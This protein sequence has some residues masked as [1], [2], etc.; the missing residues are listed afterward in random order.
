M[1]KTLSFCAILS[2]MALAACAGPEIQTKP[3]TADLAPTEVRVAQAGD[4]WVAMNKISGK[5]ESGSVVQVSNGVAVYQG[6]DGCTYARNAANPFAPSVQWKDCGGYTGTMEIVSSEG[7]ILPLQVGAAQTWV[8]KG[9]NDS[10]DT[11]DDTRTC[12]VVG[13]ENVTVPAG[14]FDAFKVDCQASFRDRTYYYAPEI[15][16]NVVTL[17]THKSRHE[18]WHFETVSFTPAGTS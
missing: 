3:P 7:S 12:T 14:T 10:G 18:P 6:S 2:A 8:G 13:V 15:G 9:T 17:S 11:W 4:S 16:R 5:Q 1:T